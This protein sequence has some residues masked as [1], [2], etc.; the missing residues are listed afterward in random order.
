MQDH[1]L[2]CLR[3]RGFISIST[4]LLL[5]RRRRFYSGPYVST[6]VAGGMRLPLLF[7]PFVVVL[8]CAAAATELPNAQYL[9]CF[10]DKLSA[11]ERS[12][13]YGLV[14]S[15]EM[16]PSMCVSICAEHGFQ[17][18]GVEWGIECWCS[19]Q[20]PRYAK[21]DDRMCTGRCGGSNEVSGLDVPFSTVPLFFCISDTLI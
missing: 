4:F 14:V 13:P 15:Q 6:A 3:K 21:V 18:A 1:F 8:F 2:R 7:A 16:T 20:P 12:L 10:P 17:Y 19:K 5:R 9:G 11:R